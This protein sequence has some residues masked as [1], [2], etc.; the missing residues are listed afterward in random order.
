MYALERFLKT[1]KNLKDIR[2]NDHRITFNS[3]NAILIYGQD[4]SN[5]QVLEVRQPLWRFIQW[6]RQYE[7]IHQ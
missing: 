2:C 6:E 5:S 1:Y 4:R 7:M 3:K